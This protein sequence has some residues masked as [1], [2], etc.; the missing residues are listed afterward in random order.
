MAVHAFDLVVL[1]AGSGLDVA[2]A[3][4]REG[5]RVA[6]V[7]KGRLGGTCLNRGCIPSKMVLHA[8]DVAETLRTAST[9]G[10]HPKGHVVDF[11]A[12]V[13]RVSAH[14]DAGSDAIERA[15]ASRDNPRLFKGTARFV[16]PR[17]LAVG[18]DTLEA[19]HVLVATGARPRVPPIPGVEDVPY[20]TSTEALR[21]ERQPRSLVI[22]GGG[23][24]AAEMAHFFGALGTDVTLVVR[25]P[26][27]LAEADEDVSAGYT[28]VARTKYRLLTEHAPVE[29]ARDGDGV[30]LRVRGPSGEADVRADAVLLAT[31]VVPNSDTLD[32]ARAGVA[33]DPEGYVVVDEYLQTTAEGVFALGDAVG[34]YL[35]K[36]NA[37]HEASYAWQNMRAPHERVPVD[38]WAMPHAVFGSPQSAGVGMTEA[39]VRALGV[40]Y[41][42]GRAEMKDTGMG[43]ALAEEHGFAKVLVAAE[44]RRLLGCHVL[45]PDA[46]TLVH[47]AVVAMVAGDGSVDNLLRAVHVHPAL[48][49]VVQRAAGALASPTRP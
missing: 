44:D 31:G 39:E 2:A 28:A 41:L 37:N 6:V 48:S 12:V 42:V 11:A 17:R 10:V 25:K 34:R 45:G 13:R 20:L 14:V 15:F 8:A 33:T 35:L 47:E 40:P 26:G 43:A 18:D 30:R 21:I 46:A 29:L 32:L 5:W 38:Y 36:H 9:F 24:I 3:A 49:E 19:R 16:G 27:M 7:E 22:V 4:A 1:G 23:F